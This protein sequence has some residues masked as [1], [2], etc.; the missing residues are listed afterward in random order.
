M[1]EVVFDPRQLILPPYWT[2]PKCKTKNSYGVLTIYD[3]SYERRCKKCMYTCTYKLPSLK[4]KVIYMDQFAFSNMMKALNPHTKAYEKGDNDDFWVTLFKKLD[5]LV[6]LQLIVCPDSDIHQNES[7][8][9]PFFKPLKRMY[10]LLS[11]GISFNEIDD[12]K[13]N[14][15]CENAEKWI[16]ND[17]VDDNFDVSEIVYENINAWQQRLIISVD[18]EQNQESIDYIRRGRE[19]VHEQLS[20]CFEIWQKEKDKTFWDWF[21]IQNS[22]FGPLCFKQYVEYLINYQKIMKGIIQPSIENLTP[23]LCVQF[24]QA[25]FS[26]FEEAGISEEKRFDK[27]IEYFYSSSLKNVPFVKLSSLL[28]AALARKAAAGRKKPPNQGT[29]NDFNFI[30]VLLPFCDAMFID[31]ECFGYLMEE[32]ISGNIS[33]YDT[34]IF[35]L[36]NK[37]AFLE[38]L[39]GIEASTPREHFDK[40]RE[41]YGDDWGRPYV[42]LYK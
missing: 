4:K 32:P 6:K 9:T 3:N 8:V 1:K 22:S 18:F 40:V 35:S 26:V 12:I 10:E 38:Y 19:N 13:I 27:V 11:H 5:R 2:C 24:V 37:D 39:D 33:C 29:A 34:Q 21:N 30:S 15:I 23:S 14:Q 31:N 16:N 7:I 17:T 28:L 25:A 20:K 41:V 42:T 36:N